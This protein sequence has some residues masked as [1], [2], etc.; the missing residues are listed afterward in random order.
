VLEQC[1]LVAVSRPGYPAPDPADLER[2]VPG[3]AE[4]VLVLETPGVA[5][6]A[7]DLRERVA[8]GRSIR[9]LVPEPVR[10]LI[11]ARRLYRTVPAS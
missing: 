3:A 1:I 11:E 10:E 6:S 9:Y 7:T 2:Q 5:I 8:A 4:R